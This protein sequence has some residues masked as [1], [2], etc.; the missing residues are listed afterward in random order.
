MYGPETARLGCRLTKGR[1][2]LTL[3]P[4]R[5]LQHMMRHMYRLMP[6]VMQALLSE[7]AC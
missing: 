6:R 4:V 2:G 1:L 5:L 7:Y 3:L